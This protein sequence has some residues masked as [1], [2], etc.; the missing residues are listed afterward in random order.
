MLMTAT[1]RCSL[2]S[3]SYYFSSMKQGVVLRN[4]E[5]DHIIELSWN[6][7]IFLMTKWFD[8][9]TLVFKQL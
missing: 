5:T 1:V 9:V 6:E 8:S 2:V 4:Q 3:M 7:N